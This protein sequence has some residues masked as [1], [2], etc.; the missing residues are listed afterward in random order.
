MF[1]VFTLVV[2]MILAIPAFG[3][4][5]GSQNKNVD[6]RSPI[7]DLHIGKDADAQKAGLPLYPGARL[8]T[9]DQNSEPANLAL[10]TESFGMKLI[11]AKYESDDPPAKIVEFYR[12]KL[13]KYGK[14][15]ECHAHDH[16]GDVDVNDSDKDSKNKELKC[17]EN[18]GP[19]TELKAGTEDNQHI[20][21][22]EPREDKGSTFSIVYV[23]TRKE[24]E[25]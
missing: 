23:H 25:I 13:K 19:V 4:D 6:V 16:G 8:K 12:N 3:Q 20:V 18:S 1:C 11:V 22:V 14:V 10:L 21:A 9:N 17:E 5:S 2:A 24:G 7:G 15:L